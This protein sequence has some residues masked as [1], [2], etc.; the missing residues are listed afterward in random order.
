MIIRKQFDEV[1]V[2]NYA[3]SQ[4][5]PVK[6]EG[7]KV[8]DQAGKE[9][10]DFAGGIAV[11]A[12]GH[13]HPELVNILQTQ[14]QTLWHLSNVWTNEPALELA[15][16]L[17]K[18]TFAEQVLFANSGAEANEAALKLA[19][20]HAKKQFNNAKTEIIAFENSFHGRTLFTV[21]TGGQ[22][23]YTE[24][25][26]PLP[27]DITHLPFNNLAAIEYHI[28]DRTCAVIVEPIQGE[29]GIIA[30]EP[31][32]L[33]GLRAL[34]SKYNA[35][36][37]FDE[38]QTG[39]GRTGNLFAYQGYQV[40]PDILTTA[41]ALGCGFPIGAM[42]TT[43]SIGNSFAVGSHGSTYGGNPLACA[44]ALKALELINDATLLAGVRQRQQMFVSGL[45]QLNHKIGLFRDIRGEGL[46]IGCELKPAWKGKAR[47]L[48]TR[49]E[50]QGVLILTAGPDIVRLAPSL[51]I[52]YPD[53]KKGLQRLAQAMLAI[54]VGL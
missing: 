33:E 50:E 26:E 17:C 11:N 22:A 9:Y 31:V 37:I 5:I 15:T 1:M 4:M 6:G 13:C 51:I 53:I 2:P 42:L 14:G 32:F 3:P 12:L 40:T 27:G 39:M 25:F 54:K 16:Q 29:G 8:W 48:L 41:K 24:G 7:S 38:I 36:L 10:I 47:L 34:C 20:I 21:S 46:L 19:R 23:K 35:L 45:Q 18:A 52:P 30:A 49:A 44:V 43:R 28:S